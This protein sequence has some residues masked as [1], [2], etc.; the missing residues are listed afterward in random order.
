MTGQT[1]GEM[2]LSRACAEPGL[3]HNRGMRS[4]TDWLGG[5]AHLRVSDADRERAAAQLQRACADG[6]L[7]ADELDERLQRAFAARTVGDLQALLADL[8]APLSSTVAGRVRGRPPMTVVAAAGV[9]LVVVIGVAWPWLGAFG[10][11]LGPHGAGLALF[12]LMAIAVLSVVAIA[13]AI[14]A[15]AYAAPFVLIGAAVAA[16]VRYVRHGDRYVRAP[17]RHGDRHVRPPGRR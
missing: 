13:V 15:V 4:A 12:A 8:P 1:L 3:G 16:L 7:T 5:P 17:E 10:A 9:A 14:S 11:V 2:P 6:R